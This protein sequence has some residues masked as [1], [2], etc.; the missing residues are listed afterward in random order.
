MTDYLRSDVDEH[1]H[2]G[3]GKKGKVDTVTEI[4]GSFGK[5]PVVDLSNMGS[6]S[7]E[8]RKAVAKAICDAC[9][10][11]GFFYIKNHGVPQELVDGAFVEARRFFH[12][13]SEDQKM[14]LVNSKNPNFYG[15][16]PIRTDPMRSA[17]HMKHLFESVNFGYEPQFDDAAVGTEDNGAS[18]WPK[19]EDLPD[20][21][22][23]LGKYYRSVI[24]LS[25]NLLRMFA[26]GLDLDEDF[27]NQFYKRPA[28]LLKMNHYPKSIPIN[29]GGAKEAGI[30]AHTDLQ[31]FTIL[32]QEDVKSLEVL[33]KDGQWVD[34]EP[35]RG[36]FVVN[37]GD[38]IAMWTND[39]F[40]STL[41]RVVNREG[42]ARYSIPFCFGPDF[43]AVMET[44]PSCAT[45]D[46][47]AKYKTIT[48]GEY[49]RMRLN[50]I[51]P[52]DD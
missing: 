19:E 31:G 28:T 1:S 24:D 30:E 44:L 5:I 23:N 48:A 4:P 46:R 2:I 51:Y 21:K 29:G 6:P 33:L 49:H 25:R 3:V 22:K 20:F 35:V 39:L 26:L 11:V 18:F 9:T 8:E 42:R 36:A 16:A 14:E 47:P 12:E 45:A 40:K 17:R 43:D 52:K 34:A 10:K 38:S 37:I 27:F 50:L 41:H 13:L 15:Y 7:I 32:A